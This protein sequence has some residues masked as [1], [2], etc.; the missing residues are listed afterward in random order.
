MSYKRIQTIGRYEGMSTDT[1]PTTG[2]KEGSWLRELDT[3]RRFKMTNGAWI[4]DL[5]ETISTFNYGVTE[6]ASRRLTED[7]LN[8]DQF[9][10][11][12]GYYNFIENR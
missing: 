6:A 2:I 1:K 9:N 11:G 10:L 5:S 7:Q 12:R 3:G 8:E 4:E